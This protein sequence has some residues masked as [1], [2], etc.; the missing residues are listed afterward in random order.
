MNTAKCRHQQ[1]LGH[2]GQADLTM[3]HDDSCCDCCKT[4]KD[5]QTSAARTL[6][7]VLTD[8][9][10]VTM[11]ALCDTISGEKTKCSQPHQEKKEFGKGRWYTSEIWKSVLQELVGQGM[12]ETE[13]I[14][15]P[16]SDINKVH[17]Q[18][19][20]TP[21]GV[22]LLQDLDQSVMMAVQLNDK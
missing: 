16:G 1:V 4:K 6:L 12:V 2:F 19:K 21:T 20:A 13:I 5:D 8:L 14:I 18:L 9:Q 22:G 10:P 15:I 7:Q 17:V 11:S 3:D